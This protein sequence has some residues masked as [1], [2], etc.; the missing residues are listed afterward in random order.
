MLYPLSYE[1]LACAFTQHA[2]QA[3]VRWARA[4]Y[5]APDGPCHVPGDQFLITAPT[6]GAECTSGAAGSSLQGRGLQGQG[7]SKWGCS[8]CDRF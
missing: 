2:G 7:R 5:L 1:G 6:R 4:G 8:R 3:S